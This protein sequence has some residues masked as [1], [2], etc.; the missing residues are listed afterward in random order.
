MTLKLLGTTCS[1]ETCQ[2]LPRKAV[3]LLTTIGLY[4]H[5]LHLSCFPIIWKY[6]HLLMLHKPGKP[7][8]EATSYRLISLV[9][10][11]SKVFQRLFLCRFQE[12]FDIL[13]P[14]HQLCF[15]LKHPTIQQT[16]HIV[17]KQ[18]KLYCITAFLDM[19][20]AFAKV[21][22]HTGILIKLQHVIHHN[23]YLFLQSY[24]S[25]CYF[26][27]KHNNALSD[28]HPIHSGVPQGSVLGPIPILNIYS[29]QSHTSSKYCDSHV[30]RRHCHSVNKRKPKNCIRQSE[31]SFEFTQLLASQIE[32]QSQSQQV[33]ASFLHSSWEDLSSVLQ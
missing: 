7:T 29:K 15:C 31:S 4:N 23:Y 12:D 1:Q 26:S 11:L 10:Y 28:V 6:A 30:R 25:D 8:H 22:W 33:S 24:L 14:H 2:L 9:S 27:V 21:L 16:H 13:L 17:T 18:W 20:Q 5:V 32:N 19:Y 3:A